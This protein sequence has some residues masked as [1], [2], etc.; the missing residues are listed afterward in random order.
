M[1]QSLNHVLFNPV[2]PYELYAMKDK[3]DAMR[4]TGQRLALKARKSDRN[5]ALDK[6]FSNLAVSIS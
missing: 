2:L 1:Y 4:G 5:T 6:S 3:P